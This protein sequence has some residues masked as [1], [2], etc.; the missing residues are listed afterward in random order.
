MSVK[1]VP[2]GF[3]TVTPQLHIDGAARA[4]DFYRNAFGATELERAMDPSGTKIWHAMLRIGNSVVFVNDVFREMDPNAKQSNSSLW[5]YVEDVDAWFKRAVAA[6]A[7]PAMPPMDAFWGDRM[8]QVV[9]PFGQK[10][11]I[12][13]HIKDMTPDEIKAAEQAFLAEMKKNG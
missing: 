10:W 8:G 4:I 13:T 1:P 3:T 2:E 9:D 6:G 7:T 11:T 5:L 12:A